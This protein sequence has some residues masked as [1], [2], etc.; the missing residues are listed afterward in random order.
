MIYMNQLSHKEIRLLKKIM[1][2]KRSKLIKEFYIE[3]FDI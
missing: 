1:K 3:K 2:L